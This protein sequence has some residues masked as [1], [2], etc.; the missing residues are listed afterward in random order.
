M[1]G[2]FNYGTANP[3]KRTKK[4]EPN[5]LDRQEYKKLIINLKNNMRRTEVVEKYDQKQKPVWITYQTGAQ[6]YARYTCHFDGPTPEASNEYKG[7]HLRRPIYPMT[8][9]GGHLDANGYRW[10]GEMLGKVY[11]QTQIKGKN[12]KPLQPKEIL[13]DRATGKDSDPIS[14][15]CTAIGS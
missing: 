11:Y 6:I 2:E 10:F 14:C 15:T 12:F 3:E 8:D 4:N 13:L 5:T 7:Y 9:R 1:Q